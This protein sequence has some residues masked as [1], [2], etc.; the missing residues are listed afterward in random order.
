MQNIFIELLPPWVETGIQ[1]A[2]YDK[3]S[4]TV[5]QQ[6]S[7]MYAKINQLI[8]SVN[9]QNEAINNQNKTIT[10]YIQKFID[11]KDYVETYL[12]NLDVQAEINNKLDEMAQ[13]GQ[14]SDIIAQYIQ[15]Q[16]VLAYNNIAELKDAENLFDGS[17]CRVLGNGVYNDG[18]GEWF[19]IRTILSSDIIDEDHIFK[20]NKFNTLIAE[21]L[22]DYWNNQINERLTTSINELESK[23]DDGNGVGLW[24]IGRIRG[25]KKH[26]IFYSNDG[27]KFQ[28]VGN[29][30]EESFFEDSSNVYEIKGKFY[31]VGNYRYRISDDLVNW[32]DKKDIRV[33][34]TS[35]DTLYGTSMW[36]DEENDLVYIY[37]GFM[38]NN[39]TATNIYNQNTYYFKL[40]Y[41][42]ATINEDGSLN[43]END[44]H[45]LYYVEG[46]SFIDPSVIKD[47]KMGMVIAYKNEL[48]AQICVAKMTS[49]T[50]INTSSIIT[51]NCNGVEAPML[52]SDNQGNINCY[53]DGYLVASTV[54]GYPSG[55]G[56]VDAVIPIAQQGAFLSSDA[57]S[58][59]PCETAHANGLRHMGVSKCSK[60]AF[61]LLTKIGIQCENTSSSQYRLRNACITLPATNGNKITNHPNVIW[62]ING[63]TI[64]VKQEFKNVPLKM[65]VNGSVTWDSSS[66]IQSVCKGKT[67]SSYTPG[68]TLSCIPDGRGNSVN[69]HVPYTA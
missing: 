39:Q 32:S 20:L 27:I 66:S 68:L 42:T 17:I 34:S 46:Q 41:K 50:S 1:P 35:S 47:N 58:M 2:F 30:S 19:K 59:I 4:G 10:D 31:Y 28:N 24:G 15:L 9:N 26:T 36:Y 63:G 60:K 8:G 62:N 5:L 54:M 64:I 22:P 57:M 6:V 44:F 51:A 45:D 65:I 7:R 52:I 25:T 67:Y 29:E 21:K 11:F 16:G 23:I 12:N 33:P 37:T 38:Y 55:A 13:S 40:A 48:T 53:V 18:K 61:N 49:P 43:I 69:L 14:L 3:E 56:E